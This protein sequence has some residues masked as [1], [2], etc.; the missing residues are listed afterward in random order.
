MSDK[1]HRCD[2]KSK[3]TCPRCSYKSCSLECV[4]LHKEATKCTGIRSKTDFVPR[5]QYGI[6]NLTSG[7][8]SL[9]RLSF[10]RRNR[11]KSRFT[12]KTNNKKRK[13]KCFGKTGT[14][15][16]YRIEIDARRN[17]PSKVESNSIS[18]SSKQISMDN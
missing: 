10:S 18:I 16:Q 6:N 8:F 9:I 15:T 4:K 3:Y 12:T 17:V 2:Q 14:K 1:C 11:F 5:S 7:K 13:S